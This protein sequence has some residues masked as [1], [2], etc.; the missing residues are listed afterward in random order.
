V[1]RLPQLAH[2]Y[3]LAPL[4]PIPFKGEKKLSILD[5]RQRKVEWQEKYQ[6]PKKS[7]LSLIGDIGYTFHNN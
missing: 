6:I 2:W 7:Q 5:S 1:I 3:T 4:P